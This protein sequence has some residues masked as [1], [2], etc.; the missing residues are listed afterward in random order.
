MGVRSRALKGAFGQHGDV[1]E[2]SFYVLIARAVGVKRDRRAQ[3]AGYY[4][5]EL[6]T[7]TTPGL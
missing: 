2:C 6:V 5:G 7:L 1:S 4:P 3:P